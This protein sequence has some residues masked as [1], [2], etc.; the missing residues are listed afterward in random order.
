MK[1]IL[2]FIVILVGCQLAERDAFECLRTDAD[3]LKSDVNFAQWP[4]KNEPMRV[5]PMLLD[6]LRFPAITN[7]SPLTEKSFARRNLIRPYMGAFIRHEYFLRDDLKQNR[8]KINLFIAPSSMEAHEYLIWQSVNSTLPHAL[9]VKDFKRA[10]VLQIGHVCFA[11]VKNNADR[12]RSI[13]FIRNNILVDI[14]AEGE[15]FER[16]TRGIA[17]TIDHLLLKQKT[18]ADAVAYYNREFRSRFKDEVSFAYWC[19]KNEPMRV[20]PVL[21]DLLRF[22]AITNRLPLTE[23]SLAGEDPSRPNAGPVIHH[24]Y[25]LRDHLKKNWLR[26]NL[27]IA[28][29]SMEAH[30]YLIWRCINNTL[31]HTM[32]VE[33]FKRVHMLR[34]GHTD[35]VN[36]IK[37][38]NR[39]GSIRFIR[40]N[41]LVEIFA[42]GERCQKETRGI[43]EAIDR[44]LLEQKTGADATTYYS[45]ELQRLSENQR[46]GIIEKIT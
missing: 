4:G 39:I 20:A 40:N 11:N 13:R 28:P 26:I 25:F 27:F 8:L 3:R 41:I 33:Q 1:K 9:R 35:Y 29:S 24:K 12:F 15:K 42:E 14:F 10:D 6:L 7:K 22:P 18:G 31:P 36:G 30:E 37:N 34:I 17:G 32:Q 44:L 16:K 45:R 43:A 19:G 23:K 2:C 38:D 21:L 5:V 46:R